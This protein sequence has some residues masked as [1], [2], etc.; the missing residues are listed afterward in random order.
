[1]WYTGA[2]KKN[3]IEFGVSNKKLKVYP[4]RLGLDYWCIIRSYHDTF[5]QTLGDI[6]ND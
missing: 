6:G 5:W 4:Y 2:F 1:M 3:Y